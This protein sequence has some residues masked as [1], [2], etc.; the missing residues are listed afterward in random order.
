MIKQSLFC[1]ALASLLWNC[2]SQSSPTGGPKDERAPK[3]ERSFPSMNQ[4]NFKAESVEL[5]FDE[6]IILFNPKDEILISPAVGKDVEFKYR[7]NRV[8][9]TPKQ[10]WAD[11]TTYSILFRE[12]IKD[13]NEGNVPPGLRLAFSTGPSIDSLSISGQLKFALIEDLPTDVTVA[14]F[15]SDTFNIFEHSPSYLTKSDANGKY[16]IE[17]LRA[18]RYFVYAFADKNKNLKV[19]STTEKYGYYPDPVLLFEA[20]DSI[21]ITLFALDARPLNMQSVRRTPV[22]TRLRFNKPVNNYRLT[23]SQKITHSFGDDRQEIAIYNPSN[24]PDSL[25]VRIEAIDSLQQRVDSTI[26]LKTVDARSIKSAFNVQVIKPYYDYSQ[27]S[28]YQEISMSLPLGHIN[29]DSCSIIID[30]LTTLHFTPEEAKLDSTRKILTIKKT[31]HPDSLFRTSAPISI[32]LK[33]GFLIS[34]E[35]DT[36]K[37]VT[38]SISP[39][40]EENTGTLLVEVQTPYKNFEVQLLDN[41]NAVIRTER[42]LRNFSFRFL[43]PTT[44]KL[45]LLVDLNDNGI[46][47]T[48]NP[49]NWTPPEPTIYYISPDKKFTFP[50]RANWELG[51]YLLKYQPDV[52]NSPNQRE[53]S[54]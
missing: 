8:T 34:I 20:K 54:Q 9:I 3:L 50:I 51:P 43:Q 52:D 39:V 11:T 25:A 13:L 1:L 2:A 44:Y 45:R 12:G 32:M 30:T 6:A 7:Q 42:N 23:A 14:V 15:K 40:K 35:Q 31:I 21:D 27:R 47:D 17:N 41:T 18:G 24:N 49:L 28:L 46:W 36:S 26:Y 4:R 33:K 38:N 22:T 5:E 29:Y 48:G 16:K 37:A 19:E 53:K 10:G